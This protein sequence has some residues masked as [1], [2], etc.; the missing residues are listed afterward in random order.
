MLPKRDS[1]FLVEDACFCIDSEEIFSPLNLEQ[2]TDVQIKYML[3]I[4][5]YLFNCLGIYYEYNDLNLANLKEIL[6]M[7]GY[8][9][10][11]I[12]LSK[13]VGV[14]LAKFMYQFLK[15]KTLEFEYPGIRHCTTHHSVL[16]AYRNSRDACDKMFNENNSLD[17]DFKLILDEGDTE[18]V[19]IKIKRDTIFGQTFIPRLFAV[20]NSFY[21]YV[22]SFYRSKKEIDSD[23]NLDFLFNSALPEYKD[24]DSVYN[25]YDVLYASQIADVPMFIINNMTFLAQV[26]FLNKTKF[27]LPHYAKYVYM[28]TIG[29]TSV[30]FF[31]SHK[32]IRAGSLGRTP[33]HIM[34][35][36][37][38]DRDQ[39][40]FVW[41]IDTS[42]L[43]THGNKIMLEG[44]EKNNTKYLFARN[45]EEMVYKK[46]F[47][48]TFTS[49]I[50][51]DNFK[52]DIINEFKEDRK[53]KKEYE[54]LFT[55]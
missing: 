39:G 27:S 7:S 29:N 36:Q 25:L 11:D 2:A 14:N 44:L 5:S 18:R 23:S 10:S 42:F 24:F 43:S 22:H 16:A 1:R 55:G 20:H 47:F 13:D 26:L 40:D 49:I 6:A 8:S 19:K 30:S 21:N 53:Y 33:K 54:T 46:E 3:T 34:A 4:N 51:K 52:K 12:D 17:Q 28:T 32:E 45:I 50:E 35:K 48:P 37:V 41:L 38:F 9:D 15:G 31:F